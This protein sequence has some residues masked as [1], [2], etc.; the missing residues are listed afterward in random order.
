MPSHGPRVQHGGRLDRAADH[1]PFE[2][3][4]HDLDFGQFRH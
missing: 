3:G 1:M 4:A 2:P